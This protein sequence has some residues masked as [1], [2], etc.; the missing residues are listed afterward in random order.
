M[1]QPHLRGAW[2]SDHQQYQG[3]PGTVPQQLRLHR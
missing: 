1:I 3:P 2:I